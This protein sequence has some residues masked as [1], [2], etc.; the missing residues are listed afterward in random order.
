MNDLSLREEAGFVGVVRRIEATLNTVLKGIAVTLMWISASLAFISVVLRY[1][2]GS[3]YGIVEELCRFSIV[4]AV[5]LYFGPLITRNAHL[6]MT[7]VTDLMPAWFHRYFD[8]VMTVLLALLLA[9]LLR[10]AWGWEAGLYAMNL[11]TMSGEL[12]AWIPSAALPVGIALALLYTV[13]RV[14][15]RIAGAPLNANEVS[16]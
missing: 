16:E 5:L 8:L 11:D 12:K 9:V 10:A 1:L 6:A 4:Y 15:Y 3:S 2:F 14:I 13:F 7:I